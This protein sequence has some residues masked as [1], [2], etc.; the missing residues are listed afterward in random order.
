MLLVSSARGHDL[1]VTD[2]RLNLH[3]KN[4]GIVRI[5]SHLLDAWPYTKKQL[6]ARIERFQLFLF[7]PLSASGS[8]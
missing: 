8:G 6:H 4:S 3:S 1:P 7:C 2:I 5:S